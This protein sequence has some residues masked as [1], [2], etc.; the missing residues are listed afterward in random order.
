MD[1]RTI[2]PYL[3]KKRLSAKVIHD[4][5]VQIIGSDAIA[6]STVTSYLRASHWM[7]Q[8]EEQ[9]SD[10]LQML[11]TTQFSNPL[12]KPRSR[13]CGNTQNRRAFHAH[14]T[15]ISPAFHLHFTYISRATV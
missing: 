9:H 12:I 14:F 11:S 4:E 2:C 8:N 3:N 10:P 15:R 1:Q 7:A 5:F 13:Q 6:C